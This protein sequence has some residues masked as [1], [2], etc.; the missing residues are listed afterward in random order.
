M[1][2]SSDIPATQVMPPS[3]ASKTSADLKRSRGGTSAAQKS[4]AQAQLSPQVST[5][6]SE[7]AEPSSPQR[8]Q[9]TILKCHA[10]G[11]VGH[12]H[13]AHDDKL[14]RLVALKEIRPDRS[15][16]NTVKQ[17]FLNEAEITGQLEHPGIV[18]I[19]ALDH[20]ANG[21][22]YYAMR[23][24]Q[25][26]TF[27]QAIK[28]HHQNPSS[29]RF[30]ELLQRFVTVCQTIAYAHSKGVIHRDVKPSNIMLGAFGETLVL[31]WGLAKRTGDGEETTA[32]G[33]LPDGET[34]LSLPSAPT[35]ARKV[36]KDSSLSSAAP[37]ER[38][39]S[40]LTQAGQVI[41]TLAY[42]SP[43]Q[44]EGKLAE[45]GPATDIFALGA[46]LYELLTGRHPYADV[47]QTSLV[48]QVRQGKFPPPRQVK[49]KVS[50]ALA[51]ICL[52]ATS[53]LPEERYPSATELA[54]DVEHW[55][56]DEPVS[57][58]AE[59]WTY[60]VNR[61][62]RRHKA[63]VSGVLV[64]LTTAV[65]ALSIGT[66][67]LSL[68]NE[69]T[70]SERNVALTAKEDAEKARH[71]AEYAEKEAQKQ[72]TEANR[73]AKDAQRAAAEAEAVTNFLVKDMIELASPLIGGR[74]LTVKQ[75]MDAAAAKIPDAFGSQPAVEASIR[76]TIGRSYLSLGFLS[77][78]R[79][80]LKRALDLRTHSLG[81]ENAATL[82]VEFELCQSLLQ[83][84]RHEEAAEHSW[85][86]WTVLRRIAGDKDPR[87]LEAMSMLGCV[88]GR[89]GRGEEGEPLAVRAYEGL[90]ELERHGQPVQGRRLAALVNLSKVK[91]NRGGWREALPLCRLA[92]AE[93]ER[94]HG[95]NHPNTC[96]AR[97]TLGA[98]LIESGKHA[99][100]EPMLRET[101]PYLQAVYGDDNIK[102]LTAR[103]NLCVILID[104]GR[105]EEADSTTKD[106]VEKTR[107]VL[108]P[109][110][111]IRQRAF[112][113][114]IAVLSRL[115]HFHEVADL[116]KELPIKAPM[117]GGLPKRK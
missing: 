59:P 51:A 71:R 96:M 112:L 89:L 5:E 44:A 111:P 117:R 56:A 95:R 93:Q 104:Q 62:T 52:K 1:T 2:D 54:R 55:L 79:N 21:Q 23:F 47:P 75:A 41:G 33:E 67:L 108:P 49:K 90:L 7:A 11:G 60:R 80:H 10:S 86:L 97:I 92:L 39:S 102:T 74:N 20:D 106:L 26:Q 3:Q 19:Y 9:F 32:L 110:H 40:E 72:A 31:D 42:M 18:P 30:R 36:N 38:S 88:L 73:S 68:A 115:G 69:E 101:L 17:R 87:T 12:V 57:A 99:E 48:S 34:L 22:L 84:G 58:F 15:H 65:V 105:W 66:F 43:E 78:A 103:L 6:E 4:F 113:N 83:L 13:L 53:Y 25:G 77:E 45:L 94:L 76:E 107:R 14:K 37:E 8:G 16:S 85:H 46:V 63:L 98:A 29:L 82:R 50:R 116:L 114:R 81:E 28:E 100:A 64:L 24:I 27:S 109:E 91:C 35:A 61:W 70:R